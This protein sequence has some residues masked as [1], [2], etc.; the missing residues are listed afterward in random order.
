MRS[1]NGEFGIFPRRSR[2]TV[3]FYYWI[4]DDA[5]K[6]KYRSTGKQDYNEAL[7]YCRSLQIRGQLYKGTSYSFDAYTKDFFVFESCPYISNRLLRGYTYG[8][9]W[10]KRQRS[11]LVNII[12]PRFTDTDIR[13][14]TSKMID[15][16]ILQLRKAK[17]GAKTLN[18][19][20]TTLKAV[21]GY[22]EKSG[23]L[24]TNPVEGIKPF[25]II[26]KEKGIF[27]KEELTLLFSNPEHSG[28]W[29][30]P[31]HYLLNYVAAATGL[32][33]GEILA[34]HPENVTD[35][36]ISVEYSWNRI[37][38]LKGTTTGKKRIVPISPGL[39]A[40]L[41]N[42]IV[43]HNISGFIFSANKG[44]TPIDHKAVYR[45][46]WFALTKSGIDYV[47]RNI[48]FHSYRHSFNTML[49]EAGVNPETIRLITGH[50]VKMT[51]H[52]SHIQLGNMPEI[53][54]KLPVINQPAL[55]MTN[56][57]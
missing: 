37:E 41:S 45:H 21:F 50:S 27:T 52:Y 46:F 32:R 16:F 44:Q 22:A 6:R 51:A 29:T 55:I 24:E 11:I 28:I 39:A 57:V 33:L 4:Y 10:A 13:Y 15:D 9:T 30:S 1:K 38:G 2:K 40:T 19:I 3:F 54:E 23:L 20:L 47:P 31:L 56:L 14:I 43:T 36:K 49:L 18:H 7:K 25:K 53:V 48:T 17:T 26:S 35:T 34:L 12:Q 5:G 8:K 42:Y